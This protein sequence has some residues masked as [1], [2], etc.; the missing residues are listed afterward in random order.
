MEITAQMVKE[1]RELTGAGMMDC[2]K[3]LQ[4][5]NGVISD[6]VDYLREK[7]L[8][9]AAKKTDRQ[10][11]EGLVTLLADDN[12][13]KASIAE[14]NSETDFVSRNENFVKLTAKTVKHI[15]DNSSSI[16]TVEDL[17]AST[18]DGVVFSEFFHSQIAQ[19]GEN[20][21]V[22]RIATV[23]GGDNVIVRGYAHFNGRVGAIVSAKCDSQATCDAAKDL[24]YNICMHVSS[25]SPKVLKYTDYDAEF[26]HKEY[27]AVKA[28]VEKLN[29]ENVR[30][31]KP[32]K[33]LPEYGSMHELT[34]EVMA[35]AE[36]HFKE[37]LKAQ[38]KPEKIWGNILPGQMKR[39]VVDN[40]SVDQQYALLSQMYVL[41]DSMSVEEAI[42][43]RA[44][45][46]NGTI[47]IVEFVRFEVGEGIEKK[48]EDFAAEVA[49]QMGQ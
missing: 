4:E 20:M 28:D 45:E 6:A 1:L 37:E 5:K 49:K 48:Q 32:V 21:V 40:T 10:A 26:A 7:G 16:K 36:E 35:K 11:A 33:R 17:N 46:V 13:K 2:K 25:M 15:Y 41:D 31:G 3:A 29:E 38:N 12:F 27:L 19:I 47:E 34:P 24:I 9:K 18:I 39:F 30:L 8:G 22:R 14:I 23:E 42:A 43:K 44:K